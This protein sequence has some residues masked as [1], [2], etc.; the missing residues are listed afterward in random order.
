MGGSS[1]LIQRLR[2]DP[3]AYADAARGEGEAWA[4]LFGSDRVKAVREQDRRAAE[5]LWP[6]RGGLSLD[7]LARKNGWHFARG[8]SLACGNGW[9]ERALADQ[10]VCESFIGIDISPGVLDEAR[11]AAG[12][13][14]FEY[15]LGD[16]NRVDLGVGEYDLVV[17][18][19]CLH[20]VLE[21][22]YLA[23]QIWRCLK[24]G[25]MLWIDDFV[26]ETQFQWSDERLKVVN[27]V[28]AVLPPRYRRFRLHDFVIENVK[29]AE[30]GTLASPF[31]AI[32]S[33][34]IVDVF[35]RRF[36]VEIRAE[37]DALMHLVCPVGARQNYVETDDGP[38]LFEVLMLLD[39]L[40]IE[41]KILPPVGGQYVMRKR[42][43]KRAECAPGDR[44]HGQ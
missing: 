22:E 21:L 27:D 12:G 43:E 24:P 11:S 2:E 26:G 37:Q 4:E 5:V 13:R 14:D 18:Q 15:R 3:E 9:L 28:L 39:R 10:G 41:H 44:R 20:H 25:G 35:S 36:E 23:D 38:V 31:E 16:L 32:R 6:G 1:E 7:G 8:L 34:E 42:A 19:N 40:L 17:T 33:G 29:R 30:A